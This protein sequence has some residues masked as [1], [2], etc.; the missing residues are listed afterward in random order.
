MDLDQMSYSYFQPLIWIMLVAAVIAIAGRTVKGRGN[1]ETGEKLLDVSFA[2]TLVA[3]AYVVVL[4]LLTLFDEPDLIYDA[5]VVL[6]VIIRLLRGA[7][8]P[9][10]RGLRADRRAP[11]PP[12][13][14]EG[15]CRVA[16]P[17][18]PL[19]ATAGSAPAPRDWLYRKLSPAGR[20]VAKVTGALLLAGLI[21]AAIVL[22]PAIT[23]SKRERA[24]QERREEQASRAAERRRLI[25]EQRPRRG[26]LAP[27]APPCLRSRPRSPRTPAGAWRRESSRLRCSAPTVSRSTATRCG[28]C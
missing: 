20:R 25:A 27:R 4:L 23:T 12:A 3:G 9:A 19:R 6:L 16:P 22:V 15:D 14:A 8:L 11:G 5:L 18:G 2:V 7:G 13:A 24:A 17:P 10:V 26:R 21:A 28:R 1:A